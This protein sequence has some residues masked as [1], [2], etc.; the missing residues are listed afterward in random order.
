MESVSIAWR[1]QRRLRSGRWSA[2][3]LIPGVLSFLLLASSFELG[4]W[5]GEVVLRGC[6]GTDGENFVGFQTHELAIERLFRKK[7]LI[8][9][10]AFCRKY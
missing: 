4:N 9:W 6:N 5:E 8:G 10:D 1:T 3:S 2:L 7:V